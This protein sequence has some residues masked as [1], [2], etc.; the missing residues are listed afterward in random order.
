MPTGRKVLANF[1]EQINIIEE[2]D[3][4]LT[5]AAMDTTSLAAY[6]DK[7]IA[8]RKAAEEAAQKEE[9]RKQRRKGAQQVANSLEQVD[10]P[11]AQAEEQEEST[12]ENWY[13]Y[14]AAAYGTG[15]STFARKWGN[16]Q[17]EDNWRRTD[18]SLNNLASSTNRSRPNKADTATVVQDSTASVIGEGSAVMGEKAQ[19]M[20]ALP[21]TDSAKQDS[22]A[23]IEEAY[24]KLGNIF[25]FELE[26]PMNAVHTFDT[27]LY[28]FPETEYEPEVLYQLYL[29]TKQLEDS[30][31]L[32]YKERLLDKFPNSTF[33]KILRNPNYREENNLLSKQLERT[34]KE[35]YELYRQE[36]Y[37]EALQMVRENLKLYPDNSFSDHLALLQARSIG[38]TDG[39]L[40]YQLAL[41][42]F[43]KEYPDSE[44]NPYVKQLQES[45][46][47]FKEKNAREQAAKYYT[48]FDQPHT[49]VLVYDKAD[50][51]TL[52]KELLYQ[53]EV[54]NSKYYKEANL[55]TANLMLEGNKAMIIVRDFADKPMA[56]EYYKAFNGENSPL[57]S[58]T[59]ILVAETTFDNF[60]ITQDNFNVFYQTK[61]LSTYLRFFENNYGNLSVN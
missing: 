38:H 58:L 57:K 35:A 48:A 59:K 8:E 18:K 53:T 33:A 42:N 30:A 24:Y 10:N 45:I 19:L 3:S 49:F 11:F 46:K 47:N 31:Y 6:L 23:K 52:T 5:L 4:L 13:F 9:A 41:Q 28:R 1:V 39:P 21:L 22:Y 54:F 55:T 12:G 26:E 34:Y 32:T 15:Q 27:L 16:R 29:I 36:H 40:Q 25:N 50:N 20:A 61:D 14:N 43:E 56:A 7:V 37:A 17:L 44:L 51:K 60:V 2:Q